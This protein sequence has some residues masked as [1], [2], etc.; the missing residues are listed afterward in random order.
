MNIVSIMFCFIYGQN[1]TWRWLVVNINV[2][3]IRFNKVLN[4]LGVGFTLIKT[5]QTL[6]RHDIRFLG[7]LII[8]CLRWQSPFLKYQKIPVDMLKIRFL[9]Y[10]IT[11]LS[12]WLSV[13][14]FLSTTFLYGPQKTRKIME[15]RFW[16][17]DW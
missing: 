12:L 15:M 5:D 6:Y 7:R 14:H 8:Y 16:Y 17:F 10:R 4:S 11:R 2:L 1:F 9:L 13:D 3:S